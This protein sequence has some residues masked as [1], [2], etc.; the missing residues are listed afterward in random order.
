MGIYTNVTVFV[1]ALSVTVTCSVV[2]IHIVFA[3]SFLL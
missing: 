1:E 2:L 3:C